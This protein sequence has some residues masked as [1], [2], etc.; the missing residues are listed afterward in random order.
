MNFNYIPNITSAAG[1]ATLGARATNIILTNFVRNI[2]GS[3]SQEFAL[4]RGMMDAFLSSLS[5]A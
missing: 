1:E 5:D 4:C 3:T 2:P